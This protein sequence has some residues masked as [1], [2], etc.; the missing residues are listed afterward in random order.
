VQFQLEFSAFAAIALLMGRFGTPEMAGHQIALNLASLTFMVPLGV[1]GAAA[2]LVGQAVGR[3]DQS[4]ARASARTSLIVGVGFM[5]VS[6][7]VMLLVPELIARLY[8][9]DPVAAALAAMLIPIAGVFQIFDGV[10]AVCGG[11]LRGAGDTRTPMLVNI[12]GFWLIGIPT[13]LYLGFRTPAGPAGLWWGLVA[14]LAAVAIILLVRVRISL[15]RAL[16][17]LVMDPG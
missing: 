3:G 15:R 7:A 12:I 16:V 11:V 8:T 6:A 17:R 13:S 14:G 1:A 2:V 5:S 10:Q 9:S 4:G